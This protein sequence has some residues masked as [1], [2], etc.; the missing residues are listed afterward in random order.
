MPSSNVIHSTFTKELSLPKHHATSSMVKTILRLFPEM[1]NGG[2][3]HIR[4]VSTVLSTSIEELLS[5]GLCVVK[6]YKFPSDG[7]SISI[8]IDSRLVFKG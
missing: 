5:C 1:Q 4:Q 8:Y 7:R 3:V 6:P 2:K